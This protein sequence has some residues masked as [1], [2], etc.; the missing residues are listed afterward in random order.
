MKDYDVIISPSSGNSQLSTTNLT[1]H[2]AVV[3]KNGYSQNGSPT[4]ITFIGNLY[5]E[6]TILAVARAYQEATGFDEEHP[7]MFI[8]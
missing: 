7:P 4:S 8:K 1:G 3:M 2:P 6:A 5:D